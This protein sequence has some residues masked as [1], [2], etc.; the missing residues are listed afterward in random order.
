MSIVSDM[1]YRPP[2]LDE[3]Q[4]A[5]FEQLSAFILLVESRIQAHPVVA[6]MSQ[7]LDLNIG[8]AG[9]AIRDLI[10]K[11]EI[12]DIDLIINMNFHAKHAD[13]EKIPRY[14][15]KHEMRQELMKVVPEL[16]INYAKEKQLLSEEELAKTDYVNADQIAVRFFTEFFKE[17]FKVSQVYDQNLIEQHSGDEKTTDLSEQHYRDM[18]LSGVIK[19]QSKALP[20]PVDVLFTCDS[21]H[22]FVNNFDFNICKTWMQHQFGYDEKRKKSFL[23]PE[24][25]LVTPPA[26]LQDLYEN[27]I[28]YPLCNNYTHIDKTLNL[29]FR[30]FTKHLPRIMA[31]FPENDVQIVNNSHNSESMAKELPEFQNLLERALIVIRLE[32]QYQ[33]DEEDMA[34]GMK[35]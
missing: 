15:S 30:S 2:V 34:P 12:K 20:W 16:L 28:T 33:E 11:K 17:E 27:K 5:I 35:I 22:S 14:L 18:G 1:D 29:A 31:K 9:G 32:N 13:Y 8:I 25:S 19:M 6:Q 23:L 3:E 7:I 26:F 21:I 4:Q 10:A 24:F